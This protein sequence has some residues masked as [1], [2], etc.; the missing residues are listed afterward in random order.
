VDPE[1]FD[2]DGSM[3]IRGSEAPS[4]DGRADKVSDR[5]MMGRAAS[6]L[7]LLMSIIAFCDGSETRDGS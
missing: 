3:S 6:S 1:C 7:Q 4:A 5:T 2:V